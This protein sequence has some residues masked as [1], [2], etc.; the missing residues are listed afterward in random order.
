MVRLVELDTKSPLVKADKPSTGCD[1]LFCTAPQPRVESL[2]IFTFSKD[3]KDIKYFGVVNKV[4]SFFCG[5]FLKK[6]PFRGGSFRPALSRPL[7]NPERLVFS[8]AVVSR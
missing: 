4:S 2:E 1:D 5:I 3:T 7:L 6:R 8:R